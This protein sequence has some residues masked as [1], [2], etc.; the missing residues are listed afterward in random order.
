MTVLAF[1]SIA[2]IVEFGKRQLFLKRV[3]SPWWCRT[4]TS[5]S[6]SLVKWNCLTS[7]ACRSGS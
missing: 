1:D 4:A 2:Q 3:G 6:A 5:L 7:A